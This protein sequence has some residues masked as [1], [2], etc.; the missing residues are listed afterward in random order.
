[1]YPT[2]ASKMYPT[3]VAGAASLAAAMSLEGYGAMYSFTRAGAT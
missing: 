2:G 1:M 3:T